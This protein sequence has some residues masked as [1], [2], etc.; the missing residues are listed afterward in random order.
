MGNRFAPAAVAMLVSVAVFIVLV[1]WLAGPAYFG[2]LLLHIF[3]ISIIAA[4]IRLPFRR[5]GLI[6]SAVCGALIAVA[7]FLIVLA[8]AISNI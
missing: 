2:S 3:G 4:I 1:L 5:G 7:G 6:L 8:Y